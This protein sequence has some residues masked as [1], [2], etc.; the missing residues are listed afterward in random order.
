MALVPQDISW[1][2]TWTTD[3]HFMGSYMDYWPFIHG[4]LTK[5]T[6]P[7]NLRINSLGRLSFVWLPVIG[8]LGTREGRREKIRITPYP[9]PL[10]PFSVP[11]R[12]SLRVAP[13]IWTHVGYST[14]FIRV[15]KGPF[16][17]TDSMLLL[18]S[19]RLYLNF[20]GGRSF[21]QST[22]LRSQIWLSM[23][24]PNA[25]LYAINR[26]DEQRVKWWV[27]WQYSVVNC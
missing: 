27:V 11:T 9:H 22:G 4:L 24:S 1:G 14:Y 25:I 21:T 19:D 13:T 20:A 6:F 16:C 5:F 7:L 8:L 18:S 10:S 12:I 17:F 2:H 26:G 3:R 15:L 23:H